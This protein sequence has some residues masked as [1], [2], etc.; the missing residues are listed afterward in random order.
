MEAVTKF[1]ELERDFDYSEELQ[2]GLR[3]DTG[4]TER[5]KKLSSALRST[6]PGL[7]LH[8]AR[9]YTEVFSQTE[10]EP[11]EIRFAKAFYK[12][13]QD[14]PAVI[15]QGELIIGL[16]S[17]G[18]KKI[19]VLPVNQASWLINELD[20]LS[21]RKVNPVAVPKEQLDEAKKLLSYW[22]DKTGYAIATKFCPPELVRRVQGTGWAET[23]GYFHQGGTHFNPP[24]E[25][26]LEK[27]LSW[28]E[29]RVRERLSSLDYANPEHMGK[30]HFYRALL[31]VVEAV[32]DFAAKHAE[33]AR[34]LSRQER[35]PGRKKELSEIAQI[36]TRVPYCGAR[37]FREAVQS[38]WFVH[39][40]LHVE[41]TGPAYTIGRFDQFMYPY[42]KADVETGKL[43]TDEAQELIECLFL[44]IN[45]NLWLCDSITAERNPAFPQHQT[46]SVGGVNN[47]DRDASNE[48]S[49]LILE[50]AKSIRTTQPDIVLLCHP[51][52]TPYDLKLKAAELVALGMGMPKFIS[53]ETIK[54]QLMAV[55]YSLEEARVGWIRGCTEHY[56][57]GCK[58]YGFPAATKLNLGI[59]V[60][61]VLYNGRKRMPNQQMSGELVGVETGDPR[62]FKTFDEFLAAVKR[63]VAQ[64]VSDGHIAA[65]YAD[66]V[67]MRQFPILLQSLFTEACIERGRW[68][69]AGG[70]L[71]NCGPGI[72]ITGGIATIADSLAAIKKLVY[73]ER[74]IS[75]DE[76]IQAI[77][78]NFEG[79][80]PL[81]QMLINDAPKYGN[82]NHY[83]DELAREIWQ[84]Y[85]AE[86]RKHIASLGNR[87]EPSDCVVTGYVSAGAFTWATPDGRRAGEP[88]S[89]HIGPSEQRDVNGPL[90]HIKSV[91]KLGLD[92]GFGTVH[93]M[94][95][96][97]I[98]SRERLHQMVDLIDLYHSLGGHHLQINCQDKNVLMDAQ[99]HPEKYPSLLVR[100]AGYMASFVEL[101][102]HVQDEIINRTSL[103]I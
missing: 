93:N 20:K 50:A 100:V 79:Y 76:L 21:S 2:R 55:G 54:T 45:S 33:R 74:R 82:D 64:Q 16:S 32:R 65:S 92:S 25:L 35:D 10:G 30:E 18:L 101:P 26:I 84:F 19:P 59:A 86:V 95:F 73:E 63:Q 69:N 103:M 61:A 24:W 49:F 43:T 52:E 66:K 56:G 17:C 53:T 44:K 47:K 78:A 62:Q 8:P 102:K 4:S 11:V 89:N 94:Y 23:G 5:V 34:E 6:R 36:L 48:L 80:E 29:E 13:L 12:T 91:T 14:L 87:N 15:N 3:A 83:V 51:R 88:L 99:K 70:A 97:N 75:L 71:I 37:S 46:L 27:G 31:L 9:A 58:E 98:D 81:R 7:C 28:Y 40:I 38:L 22:L 77:D 72:P 41:G 90:A 60:E 68:A 96:T 1:H 85:C 42:F 39:M 57:P 67:K